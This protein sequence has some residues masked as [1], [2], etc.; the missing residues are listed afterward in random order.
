[1]KSQLPSGTTIRLIMTRC[2]C[3]PRL[4][5]SSGHAA[6]L[7]RQAAS[8]CGLEPLEWVGHDFGEGCGHTTCVLLAESHVTVHTYPET[9]HTVIAEIS[10]CDYKKD[11]RELARALARRLEE[12]FEPEETVLK[13]ERW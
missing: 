9:A 8:A 3:L 6:P 1:M 7:L 2:A 10:I 11:N 5:T 13:E 12:L 4:L